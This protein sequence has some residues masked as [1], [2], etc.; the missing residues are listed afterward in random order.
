[1][2]TFYS[3]HLDS[4]CVVPDHLLMYDNIENNFKEKLEEQEQK[5][6]IM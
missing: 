1:M 5:I 6:V 4:T 3:T 2:A